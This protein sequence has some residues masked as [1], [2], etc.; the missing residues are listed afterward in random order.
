MGDKQ[1][2]AL[3]SAGRSCSQL[4]DEEGSACAADPSPGSKAAAWRRQTKTRRTEAGE[5]PQALPFAFPQGALP[6]PALGLCNQL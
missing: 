3:H 1:R 4:N 2:P 5:S 6:P